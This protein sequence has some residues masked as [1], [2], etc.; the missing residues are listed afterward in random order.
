VVTLDADA[1]ITAAHDAGVPRVYLM[2]LPRSL[3]QRWIDQ[4]RVEH[5]DTEYLD[6]ET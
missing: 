1:A 5:P 6:V 2:C 3:M 4:M